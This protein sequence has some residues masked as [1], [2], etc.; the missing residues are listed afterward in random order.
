MPKR[1]LESE[2]SAKRLDKDKAR[3][4]IK[5]EVFMMDCCLDE[6]VSQMKAR[7]NGSV[8]RRCQML[9][10]RSNIQYRRQQPIENK[11]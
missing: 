7:R 11:K 10:V 1:L 3:K 2:A 5:L 6:T 8:S 4:V 9:D